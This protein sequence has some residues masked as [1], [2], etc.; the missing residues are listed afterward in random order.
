MY[1]LYVQSCHIVWKYDLLCSRVCKCNET[2]QAFNSGWVPIHTHTNTDTDT[3]THR[4]ELRQKLHSTS[5]SEQKTYLKWGFQRDIFSGWNGESVFLERL[6]HVLYSQHTWATTTIVT[7]RT[8]VFESNLS[9]RHGV[10]LRLE[11]NDL[12]GIVVSSRCCGYFWKCR[13][14]PLLEKSST[15]R[16][17]SNSPA[18]ATHQLDWGHLLVSFYPFPYNYVTLLKKLTYPPPVGSGHDFESMIFVARSR[19]SFRPLSMEP[20]WPPVR[21]QTVG[22]DGTEAESFGFCLEKNVLF[23]NFKL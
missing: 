14:Q 8:T 16:T 4:C 18:I 6:Q 22:K 15:N 20:P 17:L 23:T 11:S 19:F 9:Q 1:I 21:R 2:H 3:H 10:F 13:V 12:F 7:W 5:S